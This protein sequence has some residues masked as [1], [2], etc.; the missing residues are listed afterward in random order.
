MCDEGIMRKLSQEEEEGEANNVHAE[1]KQQCETA[2]CDYGRQM[3]S[4][5]INGGGWWPAAGPNCPTASLDTSAAEFI[6][7]PP[8][9][10]CVF[11]LAFYNGPSRPISG[12]VEEVNE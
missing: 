8:K 10:R 6:A 12:C 7:P 5:V 3:M 2:E 11:S 9:M 1:Q 4:V